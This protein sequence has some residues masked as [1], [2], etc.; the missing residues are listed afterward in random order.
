MDRYQLEAYNLT[1]NPASSDLLLMVKGPAIFKTI[2]NRAYP[3]LFFSRTF[4]DRYGQFSWGS[5]IKGA[6]EATELEIRQFCEFL[7]TILLIED[8]LTESYALGLH[9]QTSPTGGYERTALGTLMREA[10]P[11]DQGWNAG[12]H[13]KAEELATRLVQFI[14]QHPT[15]HRAEIVV[16]VPPSNPNKPFD[17]P[18]F[19]VQYIV[20][21]TGQTAAIASVRKARNTRPMK[22][23]RTIQEK[24]DNIKDAF[25]VD[26]E[27]FTQ[28]TVIIVDDIYHTG[29]SINEVGRTLQMA[30]AI[31]VLGLTATKT[32]Q[33]LSEE[34]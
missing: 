28:K 31:Q 14:Q 29:F 34:L 7:Q 18:T 26:E 9:G 33:D 24:L 11:Y 5:Y 32:L 4:E 23:C 20:E 10:K 27:V 19:L 16:A 30:G 12:S 17:L 21:Q 3:H 1:R 2:F 25:I 13:Q 6:D 15:Y 22:E 8:D